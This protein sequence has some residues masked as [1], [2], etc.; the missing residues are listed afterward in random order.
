[1]TQQHIFLVGPMGAGKST[2]GKHLADLLDLPFVDVDTEIESRAG[3]DIQWIFD[4]E[5]EQGFRD[6]ECKVL[7][8]LAG[9]G[10]SKVIATG[11]GIILRDENRAVLQ[12][13]GKV[14][15]LSATAEQLFERTRRDKS[16]PLLQVDDRRAV[17]A[18]LVEVRDP[19]YNQVADLVFP[20][21]SMQ[22]NKLAKKLAEALTALC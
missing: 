8:D 19:L 12:R 11:G 18:E 4:M 3:A 21:G 2:I 1:M 14:V 20:S 5:G 6:R 17:I 13:S 22:P 15:Y 9:N 7:L 16:R 10:E